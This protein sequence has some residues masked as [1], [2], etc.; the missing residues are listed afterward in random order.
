MKRTSLAQNSNTAKHHEPS[1]S[2]VSP[3]TTP[4]GWAWHSGHTDPA[5]HLSHNGQPPSRN[6][7][8]GYTEFL[9]LLLPTAFTS[10][11]HS[12]FSPLLLSLQESPTSVCTNMPEWLIPHHPTGSCPPPPRSTGLESQH[13]SLAARCSE[14]TRTCKI[15]RQQQGAAATGW[16]RDSLEPRGTWFRALW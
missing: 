4:R 6:S 11:L 8:D 13:D 5:C 12:V 7:T 9:S 15:Q 10:L 2:S 1:L 3:R 16:A 14:Q